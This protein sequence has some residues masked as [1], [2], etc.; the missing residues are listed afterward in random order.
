MQ[1]NKNTFLD[2]SDEKGGALR[3][4]NNATSQQLVNCKF[5]LYRGKIKVKTVEAI[6][7]GCELFIIYNHTNKFPYQQTLSSAIVEQKR[8]ILDSLE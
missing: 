3:F 1:V 2:G 4:I 8:L 6:E 7:A 5:Y